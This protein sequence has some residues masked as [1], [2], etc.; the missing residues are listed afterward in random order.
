MWTEG[1]LAVHWQ[2]LLMSKQLGQGRHTEPAVGM[3]AT[4]I[5]GIHPHRVRVGANEDTAPPVLDWP[6]REME[7]RTCSFKARPSLP[8]FSHRKG[9]PSRA[10]AR[11]VGGGDGGGGGKHE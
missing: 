11:G 1:S 5:S 3:S 4:Q 6:R 7:D 8:N 9:F 2:S 10:E